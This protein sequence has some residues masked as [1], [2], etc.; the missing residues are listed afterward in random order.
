MF[1]HWSGDV[2][3]VSDVDAASTE[4]TM[5]DDFSIAANFA[6]LA[7]FDISGGVDGFDLARLARAFGSVS[8]DLRYDRVADLSNDGAV[9]GD[10]LA[11]LAA[12]FGSSR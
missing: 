10:D 11:I 7:D 1:V 8:G 9:D 3:T 12:N 4:I 2:D 6:G 5:Y